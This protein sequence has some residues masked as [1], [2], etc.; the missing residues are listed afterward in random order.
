[1]IS[2]LLF[3]IKDRNMVF[4]NSGREA[5]WRCL[6]TFFESD[7]ELMLDLIET[8]N[9]MNKNFNTAKKYL[10]HIH[11]QVK[12]LESERAEKAIQ[13]M[14]ST[15]LHYMREYFVEMKNIIKMY[16]TYIPQKCND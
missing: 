7:E 6:F 1:M 2:S 3:K 13:S 5:C 10:W 15:F 8:D 11:E 12:N 16:E 9:R 14:R 4:N